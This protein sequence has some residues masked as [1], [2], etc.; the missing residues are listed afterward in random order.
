MFGLFKKPS[1]KPSGLPVSRSQ[2]VPRIKHRAFVET[3]ERAGVPAEQRPLTMPLCGELLV[4]YAFDLPD[5]FVMATPSLLEQ[6]DIAPDEVARLATANL[7]R[8][9][10]EVQFDNQRDC[11]VVHVGGDLEATVLLVD[12]VWSKIDAKL[13]GELLAVAPRR[14]R[15]VVCDSANAAALAALPGLAGE[16]FN[17]EQDQ[18]RLSQQIMVRREGRWVVYE[19]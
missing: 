7:T 1:P 4:T 16:L 11:G 9:M 2:L 5:S 12:N 18:H 10:G 15:L 13:Q 19:H 8:D 3:L 14:N 17:E 6:A